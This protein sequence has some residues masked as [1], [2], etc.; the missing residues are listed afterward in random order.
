VDPLM[1]IGVFARATRLSIRALRN[2]D[3]LG[4]LCPARVDPDSG[5]RLYAVDQFSRAGLIRRLRELEVPLSEIAEV[6]AAQ[7]PAEVHAAVERHRA[8]VTAQAARLNR[9][10][11]VLG[12]V[13]DDPTRASGWLHVYE[14]RR[15]GQPTARIVL[16]TPLSGLADALGPAFGELY[17]QL[18]AQRIAAAGPAGSRYLTG[19]GDGDAAELE[20]ELFV[21]VGRRPRPGGRV[22]AGELPSCLL[23]ATVHQGGYDRIDSA[24]TSLGR[25]IAEHDRALAGPA[26]ELYLV[27]PGPGVPPVALRT[28]VAWPVIATATVETHD[29]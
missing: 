9:I 6:L 16:R 17:A 7:T 4:L 10:A 24:Y 22:T 23:A 25:W 3:R 5:Y 1:P 26:E 27:P 12:A 8:R 14:R 20:V 13:L 15:D 29:H 19:D 2:Y 28:E 11:E 21:P 18:G